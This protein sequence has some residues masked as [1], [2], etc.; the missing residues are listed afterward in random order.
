MISTDLQYVL[1]T[2]ATGAIGHEI[3]KALAL[4]GTPL[5]LACRN[6]A[7]A[8]ALRDELLH[9]T[10][11]VEVLELDL[12]DASSVRASV[13]S[14]KNIRLAGIINNAGI[15]KRHFALSPDEHEMT[16]TVNYHNTRL[17]NELL[18]DKIVDGGAIVFTTSL[19]RFIGTRHEYSLEVDAAS[20]SQLGVYSRS[21]KA[22]TDFAASFAI[23]KDVVMRGIRVNCADPGIV[24][25]GMIKMERWF[26]RLAD[27]FF[28]PFIRSPKKGA[29]PALRA[30]DASDGS[31]RI[32][33]RYNT[34][35]INS[36]YLNHV[37]N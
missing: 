10:F 19:T 1:L 37:N 12:A 35:T 3:A 36:K 18:L 13:N 23:S 17:L 28:R 30:F 34:H 33:C 32:Y 7:K 20:Y 24:N 26:D 2:G 31:P 9:F 6:I 14:L 27:I 15:M 11:E 16:M 8:N 25:T 22:I 29:Q 21:K 4:R 5:I